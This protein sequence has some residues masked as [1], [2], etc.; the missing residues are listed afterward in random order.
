MPSIAL[1]RNKDCPSC[2]GCLRFIS[3]P[4]ECQ[5]YARFD[6]RG[7]EKCAYYIEA[8]LPLPLTP[9]E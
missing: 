4:T 1:C 8:Q 7:A 2:G 6:P 5:A 3:E 9:D